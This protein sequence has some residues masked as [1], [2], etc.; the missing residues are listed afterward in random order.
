LKKKNKKKKNQ[1]RSKLLCKRQESKLLNLIFQNG[2]KKRK[3]L[4]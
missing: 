2:R 4:I 3:K 1:L